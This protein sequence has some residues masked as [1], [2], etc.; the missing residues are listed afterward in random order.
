MKKLS[1]L[2][3]FGVGSLLFASGVVGLWSMGSENDKLILYAIWL[4]VLGIFLLLC[5]VANEY[6]N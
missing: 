2:E 3:Q 5:F 4:S 1:N 6:L